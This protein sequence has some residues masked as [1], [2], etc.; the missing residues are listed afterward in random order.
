M[1]CSHQQLLAMLSTAA[2]V[3]TALVANAAAAAAAAGPVCCVCCRWAYGGTG[4]H[5]TL[6][7]QGD[8]LTAADVCGCAKALSCVPL[9]LV[10]V[11]VSV[12]AEA[13]WCLNE[14]GPGQH[15]ACPGQGGLGRCC[16]ICDGSSA[17]ARSRW[18][19]SLLSPHTLRGRKRALPRHSF[20]IVGA[21]R[22][23][24]RGHNCTVSLR[25]PKAAHT[26]RCGITCTGTGT[27]AFNWT[28]CMPECTETMLVCTGM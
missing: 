24:G 28:E 11:G 9:L 3:P 15:Q 25:S 17:V 16:C 23:P 19:G 27:T 18:L 1:H 14:A 21:R 6:G 7:P 2:S 5:S 20:K 4:L 26:M 22:G 8:K 13:C 12:P 10:V